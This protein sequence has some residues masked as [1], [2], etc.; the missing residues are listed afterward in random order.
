MSSGLGAAVVLCA[1][2]TSP[3]AAAGTH[4]P[5]GWVRVQAF[6]SYDGTNTPQQ[7]PWKGQNIYNTTAAHQKAT[8]TYGGALLQ[9]DY[10]TFTAN[11]QNDGSVSDRFKVHA[12]GGHGLK[13]FHGST[14]IT[15]AVVAGT[16]KTT[17]LSPGSSYQI[18]IRGF[19]NSFMTITSVG[20]PSKA[21]AVQ[22]ATQGTCGC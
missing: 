12:N 7:G 21:D 1:L 14:N 8:A 3:A 13:Y 19:W 6:H 22:T 17:S 2:F 4:K 16:F 5:D 10:F 11:L 20:D 15:A 9:G 18:Q